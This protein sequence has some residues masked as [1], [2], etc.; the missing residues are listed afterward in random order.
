ML[1]FK[2]VNYC[3]FNLNPMLFTADLSGLLS[4]CNR[5][6]IEKKE[7]GANAPP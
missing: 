2:K 1:Y 5:P 6:V 4:W 3:R 7:G